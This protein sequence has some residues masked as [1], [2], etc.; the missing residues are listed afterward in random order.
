MRKLQSVLFVGTFVLASTF[1]PPAVARQAASAQPQAGLR[2]IFVTVVDRKGLP[3]SGLS[4]ADF[5]IKEDGRVR[6][7]DLAEPARP[8]MQIAL[9]IDD[10]GPSL[11]AIRQATGQFV[12]RLQQRAEFSLTTTGGGASCRAA[13]SD[14]SSATRRDNR[15]ATAAIP[16]TSSARTPSRIRR[17]AVMGTEPSRTYSAS[18]RMIRRTRSHRSLTAASAPS[19]VGW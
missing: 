7:I 13:T 11:A 14:S 6:P 1:T 15:S 19:D 12:E 5:T 16:T 10:G 2:T 4:S 18:P 9:L 8:P 17:S 3:A